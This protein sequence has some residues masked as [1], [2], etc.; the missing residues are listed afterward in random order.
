MRF[1]SNIV[2]QASGSIGGSTFSRNRYGMYIRSRSVPVN[3]NTE[4]QN[5]VKTAMGTV[6]QAWINNITPVQRTG[7]SNYAAA[8]ALVNTLGDTYKITGFNWFVAT[9]INRIAAGMTP[10]LAP[11]AELN[12]NSA[13]EGLTISYVGTTGTATVNFTT[14]RAWIGE[15]NSAVMIQVGNPVNETVNFYGGP[16]KMLGK[17]DGDSSTAP[18]APHAIVNNIG[19]SAGQK[20]FFRHRIIRADGRFSTFNLTSA[21]VS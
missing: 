21:I 14:G 20:V 13:D 10:V 17:I 9:N 6:T 15:D 5:L 12:R 8:I 4:R 16:W 2:S 7:W 18:T 11:P 3:P 1:K 19:A